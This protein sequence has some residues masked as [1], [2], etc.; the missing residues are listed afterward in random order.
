MSIKTIDSS[1]LLRVCGGA[2]PT[3][4][5]NGVDRFGAGSPR[6]QAWNDCTSG[7]VPNDVVAAMGGTT[8][9]NKVVGEIGH[10]DAY[11]CDQVLKNY[12]LGR[13]AINDW[14]VDGFKIW[15]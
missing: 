10:P 6:M 12:R 8:P 3:W 15:W 7:N 2:G 4:D 13:G 5:I 9:R 14:Q 11:G 1:E